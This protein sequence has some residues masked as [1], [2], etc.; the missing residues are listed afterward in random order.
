V[1]KL[2]RISKVAKLSCPMGDKLRDNCNQNLVKTISEDFLVKSNFARKDDE[3]F[4][5]FPFL[6]VYTTHE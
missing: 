5:Y 1:N 6:L 2:G 4:S 3:T